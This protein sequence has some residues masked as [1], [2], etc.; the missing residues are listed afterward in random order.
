MNTSPQAV[1]P[2]LE[3]VRQFLN[4]AS[5][6]DRREQFTT[7]G[8]LHAWLTDHGLIGPEDPIDETDRLRACAFRES[9]REL[10]YANHGAPMDPHAG[11]SLAAAAHHARLSFAFEAGPR[12][13]RLESTAAGLNAAIGGLLS[14]VYRAMTDGT[15]ERLKACRKD[16]CRWAFYDK[17]KNRS[18]TW[19]S[20]ATCG[21]RMK[22]QR[23][24]ER[25]GARSAS[26]GIAPH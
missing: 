1:P 22:A 5:L 21:N 11:D 9:L 26:G 3:I 24:R 20:M 10:A 23:R 4:T 18:G 7:P 14:I 6:Q 16:S 25:H 2:D 19:C 12:R 13:L 15:W 8:A 17:P